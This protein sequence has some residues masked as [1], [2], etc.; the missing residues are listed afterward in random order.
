MLDIIYFVLGVI[1]GYLGNEIVTR[2]YRRK[3]MRRLKEEYITKNVS[4]ICSFETQLLKTIKDFDTDKINE[5]LNIY[6]M[7]TPRVDEEFK[8]DNLVRDKIDDSIN[9]M[10]LIASK[11]IFYK[12]NVELL[13]K[14]GKEPNRT[15]LERSTNALRQEIIESSKEFKGKVDKLREP[16]FLDKAYNN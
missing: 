6:K 15:N 8:V 2:K 16:D 12:Q 7:D 14:T 10:V 3:D 5:L 11:I 13:K 9:D 4:K 1:L